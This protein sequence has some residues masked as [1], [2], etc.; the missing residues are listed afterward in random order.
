MTESYSSYFY[1]S[2]YLLLSHLDSV[3]F[4]YLYSNY[5]SFLYSLSYDVHHYSMLIKF[6]AFIESFSF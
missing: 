2:C 6:D 5:I 4:E 1:F 3:F